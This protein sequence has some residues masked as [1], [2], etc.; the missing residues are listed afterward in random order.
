MNV[1]SIGD[2]ENITHIKA[3]TL[4]IWEQRYGLCRGKRKES[5][6]RYYDGEDLKQI[7]RVASLY[8]R[9]I[10]ISHIA[11]FS[12]EE[13]K[14][15]ALQVNETREDYDIFLNRLMEAS[16]DLDSVLFEETLAMAISN[17]GFEKAIIEICFPFLTRIGV[18][19]LIEKVLPGQ[20]HFA[21]AIITHAICVAIDQLPAV[22]AEPANRRVLLFTPAGEYHE[23]P[24]LFMKFLL[25]KNGVQHTYMGKSVTPGMLTAYCLRN[26]VTELYFYLTTNLTHTSI[27]HY[28]QELAKQFP[29]KKIYC[30]GSSCRAISD[31][32]ANLTVFKNDQELLAFSVQSP[33]Q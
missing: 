21:S 6:H 29:D 26:S 17:F 18:F 2:I 28:V 31:S 19:W 3:H 22:A 13:I 7:L 14:N 25:K 10:K 1:F 11:R 30:Y 20:E 16:I 4:R 27:H 9:G 8:S 5:L 12:Q 15:K 32:P 24:L 23:I 33:S